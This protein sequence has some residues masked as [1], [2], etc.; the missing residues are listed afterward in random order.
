MRPTPRCGKGWASELIDGQRGG[1]CSSDSPE[2][3]STTQQ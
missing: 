2:S 3:K 1:M